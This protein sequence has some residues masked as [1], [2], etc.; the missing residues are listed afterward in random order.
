MKK[1]LLFVTS[2]LCLVFGNSLRA[3][4]IVFHEDFETVDSMVSSGVPTWFQDPNYHTNGTHCIRDTVAVNG[5]GYLTSTSFSTTGS[6]FVQLHFDQICKLNFADKGYVEVSVDNGV[7]YTVLNASQYLGSSN[8]YPVYNYFTSFSYGPT[9][10]YAVDNT[11][12]PQTSWWRTE[13]FDISSVAA[14]SSQV[15]IRFRITDGNGNGNSGNYGWLIDD[16]Y[17]QAAPHELVPPVI[18]WSPPV[19]QGTIY[20][21]GPF[22]ISDTITD[23][24]TISSA[25]LYYTINGGTP[26]PVTMTNTGTIFHGTIPAVNLG[27]TVCYYVQASDAWN[28][29]SVLPA[30]GCQRFVTSL[31]ISF[32]YVDNF[33]VNNLW[34]DSTVSGSSWELGTP[35]FGLTT[36]AHSPPNAWDVALTTA[37]LSSTITYL[38]SPIF[39]FI[40]AYNAELSFWRNHNSEAGWDGVRVECTTNGTNWW[41]LG[42]FGDPR[43]T[44]WYNSTNINSNPGPAFAGISGGWIQSKYKLDTLNNIAGPIR[45]RFVFTSDPAVNADGFSMDDIMIITPP[46]HDVGVT[47]I[48]H[49]AVYVPG[50]TNDSVKVVIH[51]FGNDTSSTFEVAY[52]INSGSPVY[53][54]H[55]GTIQQGGDD[56]LMFSSTYLVPGVVFNICAWTSYPAD[57]N[58]FNDTLCKNVFGIPKFNIPYADN[59][60]TG[61]VVWY[62]SSTIGSLWQLGTPNYS[63]TNSAH[64]SPNSWDI[65]LNTAYGNNA[66]SLLLSPFFDFTGVTNAKLSFWQN[67]NIAVGDGLRLEYTVNSGVTWVDLGTAPNDAR[68]VNWYNNINI[69]LSNH[70]GWDGNSNGWIKSYYILPS[71]ITGAYVRFRF[72]FTSNSTTVSAGVSIDDFSIVPV[73]PVDMSVLSF[74][75][76]AAIAPAGSNTTVGVVL[77]NSGT[78]TATSGNVSYLVN[79]VLVSTEAWI[80]SLAPLATTNFN[81]TT[82]FIVPSGVFS[83]CANTDFTSDG[84]RSNDT[85]CKQ[86]QGIPSFTIPYADNFDTGAVV[87]T[88]SS[89]LGSL[90][91]LG[92]PN[93]STTNSAHTPPKAWDINL[94]TAYGNNARSLLISPFFDFT[95]ITN[96]KLSF[97][98]NRNISNPGDGIRLEYT[99]NSGATWVDLGTAPNDVNGIN[100]YNNTNINFSNHPGWD[101]NSGGWIKSYYILPPNISGPYV[102]FRFVFTSNATNVL[103]GVSIDDFSIQPGSPVDMSVL[104]F[105]Q[106]GNL[107]PAGSNGTVG[108]VLKNYGTT[109]ATN[110][111]I[112]YVVNGVLTAT[113]TWFGSLAPLATTNLNFT[114]HFVIPSGVYSIC[115]YTDFTSDGDRSNDTVCRQFQGVPSFTIPYADNFDTGAVA[116]TDSSTIGSLWQLGTPNYSTTNSAHSPPKAWDINLNT[117]YGNN[118]RSLL[119]SPFFDFTG[120]VNAKLSF[121]QNRNIFSPGDGIRL[122]YTVNSGTTWNDL[123]TAPNDIN[124][125]NWYNN[126]N[127]NAGTHPGW[128]GNSGGWIKSYYLLPPNITGPY[129]RFR[130]VF[131]S[132]AT[133]VS[134]GV[135]IDDFSIQPGSPVD[136]SVVS[137][138][139]PTNSTPSGVNSDVGVVIKNVGTTTA[140]SGT[141][142][143]V[144]NGILTATEAWSGSLAPSAT[145]NFYFTTPFTVPTGAYTICAYT[146][147]LSDGDHSNDTLCNTFYG[148][149]RYSIPYADNFDTSVVV[150]IDSS[151]GAGTNWQHGTPGYAQTTGAYSPP[152]CWD[153]NLTTAYQNNARS[154][155]ISPLFDFTGAFNAQIS[156][157][158]NRNT[159][160]AWDGTRLEYSTNAGGTWSVLGIR[161]DPNAIN[162]YNK[163]SIN[164]SFLPAWDSISLTTNGIPGWQQS[165]YLYLPPNI[166]GPDVMFRFV[167][168]SDASQTAPGISID[169]FRITVPPPFDVGVTSIIQPGSIIPANANDSVKVVIHNFGSAASSNFPVAYSINFGSPVMQLYGGTLQ[170]GAYDTLTFDSVYIVPAGTFSICAWTSLPADTINSN[171]TICKNSFGI[172]RFNIPYA[173]NFDTGNVVWTNNSLPGT[174]W[175]LG[176]PNYGATNSTHSFPNSWDINLTTAYGNNALSTLTSPLFDFTGIT[177]ARLSFWQNRNILNPGDGFRLEYSLNSGTAWADLG[178]APNDV[179]GVRW[180]NNANINFSGHPGWDGNSNGWIKSYYVLPVNIAGQDVR[181]RFVFTSDNAAATDGVSIDD[182]S[183]LPGSPV[184]LN[185]FSITQP[186]RMTSSGSNANVSVVLRNLGATTVTSGNVSYKLNG[187]LVATES[188]SG[189]MAPSATSNFSF[190]TPFTVPSG[191]YSIC[192]YADFTGDADH[193]NDSLCSQYYGIPRFT[194]PFTDNFDTGAVVWIDSSRIGTNWQLGTP[195]FST[196]N[197]A[198]SAPN[199]WDINLVT[200]YANSAVSLLTSPLFDFSGIASARL[201]FWQNRNTEN[202]WD[203]TRLEYSIDAGVNWSILGTHNDPGAINW[204]NKS[205]INS[206]GLPAWDSISLNTNGIPGWQQSTYLLLPANITGPNVMFR[207]V[208]TSDTQVTGAGMSID[209]FRIYDPNVGIPSIEH[210]TDELNIYPNPT[211]GIFYLLKKDWMKNGSSIIITDVFGN[212]ILET[213][214]GKSKFIAI[215]LSSKP[216]GIYFVSVHAVSK[217]SVQK[218]ILCK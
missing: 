29:T 124:G 119:T 64:T 211:T 142:S 40:G 214:A 186:P 11:A 91:Q 217:T 84:D 133:N 45:F 74:I 171:D 153:I 195:N 215:D 28:N 187:T 199:C 145:A 135:S 156:F 75:Q 98:Q 25:T 148:I 179:N 19:M 146:D 200:G 4:T 173:D 117:A 177:Y 22:I 17:V 170:P 96:A 163:A 182:F 120:V 110:G 59:F 85:A 7:T 72:V 67:R 97:W 35:A 204:Y 47:A 80:G 86:F 183:I 23:A 176:S 178:T 155:L 109:T 100:W 125:I 20:S 134:A 79:G 69:N 26:V 143:Y 162:W 210:N 201:S 56:T 102:R 87:W 49:P 30:S 95:G 107:A 209:N 93:Y 62:D 198:Y 46:P 52:R 196:T 43:G 68:G 189:S 188:W 191:T 151:S 76:P 108:V 9:G 164:S 63:A 38:T 184:D 139:Q 41:L 175:Q 193:S 94:N 58:H 42:R 112:S 88:D 60:D 138:I 113:E 53:Q 6:F 115:A 192:A 48:L 116:W 10:W 13:V 144:L 128:D 207:F 140:S 12:I 111:N 114:T 104:S 31:G 33:D 27:D 202:A 44:N 154:Y 1:I 167:F 158:Q 161:N 103:A 3:Q 36:G 174:N 181:F 14:N 137:F 131:T 15:K 172:P 194:L 89:T 123:G 150:W 141:V 18:N 157:W 197:S 216:N 152:S 132:N 205:S 130:F 51:N 147:F 24:S 77:K 129:V 99:V 2:V 122:E 32:P 92:T 90:W 213:T 121:W 105:T 218:I 127:I 5:T 70:P 208:F 203:G 61:A 169:N 149:P 126:V 82:P 185:L 190:T 71:N 101:G 34:Q 106:P 57:G 81:F 206:S 54:T 118:A 165:T 166:T 50:N 168:T 8:Y 159:E 65:N 212:T 180:Y 136:M 66:R 39:N 83:I 37:Y 55:T 78:T 21:L 160:N 73:S 16:V